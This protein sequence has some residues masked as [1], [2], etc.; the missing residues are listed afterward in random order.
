M[1]KLLLSSIKLVAAA[2]ALSLSACLPLVPIPAPGPGPRL[3]SVPAR[4]LAQVSPPVPAA[5]LA[6]V[7][8]ICQPVRASA[9][10][11]ACNT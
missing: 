6:S 2:T 4:P 3:G 9:G 1:P 10:A 11:V 5:P 7:A 8:R